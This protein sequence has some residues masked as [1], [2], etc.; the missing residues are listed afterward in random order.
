M[1]R[2]SITFVFLCLWVISFAQ[3][4]SFMGIPLGTN[5][6][7]FKEKLTEKGY[8]YDNYKSNRGDSHDTYYFDGVFAGS[9]VTLS[10]TTTPKSKLISAVSVGFKD[11]TTER[12]DVTESYINTKYKEIE[13]SLRNKHTNA[14]IDE[15]NN[16]HIIKATSFKGDGWGINLSIQAQSNRIYKGI[17]LLYVDYNILSKAKKEYEEDF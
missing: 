6:N 3:N 5:L 16:G 10:V 17:Y 1:K 15:W 4:I 11:Y 13:Q 14:E 12:E 8:T 7:D 2:I 9:V